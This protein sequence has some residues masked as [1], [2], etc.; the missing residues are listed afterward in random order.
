MRLKQVVRGPNLRPLPGN[1]RGTHFCYI[2][3]VLLDDASCMPYQ[4][5]VARILPLDNA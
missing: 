2:K 5:Y 3:R 1:T 4:C